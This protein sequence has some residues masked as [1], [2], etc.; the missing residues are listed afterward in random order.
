ME[1]RKSLAGCECRHGMGSRRMETAELD[2]HHENPAREICRRVD[3]GETVWIALCLLSLSR[4]TTRRYTK[5]QNL[6]LKLEKY[7]LWF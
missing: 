6:R 7:H 1:L 5:G 2:D 4:I 3:E